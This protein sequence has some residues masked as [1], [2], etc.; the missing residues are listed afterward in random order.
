MNCDRY[1]LP[2]KVWL[3]FVVILDL[4]PLR[5]T[6]WLWFEA[7]FDLMRVPFLMTFS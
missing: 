7:S 2:I 3:W 6:L 5:T 1:Y 4:T